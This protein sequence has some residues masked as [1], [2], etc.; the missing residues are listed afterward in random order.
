YGRSVVR[1]TAASVSAP[2]QPDPP[3]G[4]PLLA[5]LQHHQPEAGVERVRRAGHR[6]QREPPTAPVAMQGVTAER[7]QEGVLGVE[8]EPDSVQAREGLLE[9]REAGVE[10]GVGNHAGAPEIEP[11]ALDAE[12]APGRDEALVQFEVA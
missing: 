7:L 12:P 8:P 6:L 10:D 5:G 3:A 1:T 4:A 11:G 9:I 2:V